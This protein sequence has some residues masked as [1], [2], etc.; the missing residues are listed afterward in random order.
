M[1]VYRNPNALPRA[2]LTGGTGEA[3]LQDVSPT[4][5][6]VQ[7]T[8]GGKLIV[9][10][11]WTLGWQATVN[12]V[13]SPVSLAGGMWQQVTLPIGKPAQVELRYLPV[14][15]RVGLYEF[16]LALAVAA[17]I[18]AAPLGRRRQG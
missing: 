18:G 9:A 16:C 13:P 2:R 14:T 17:G 15:F 3:V 8:G 4:R 7:V 10:D 5:V 6:K 12:G 11:Q 1:F